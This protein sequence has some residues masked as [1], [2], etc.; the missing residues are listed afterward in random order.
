MVRFEQVTFTSAEATA[1]TGVSGTQQRNLRRHGYLDEP[2]HGTRWNRYEPADLAKLLLINELDRLHIPP[3][4]SSEI[5][6]FRKAAK[7]A[8]VLIL[9]FAQEC[10]GTLDDPFDRAGGEKPIKVSPGGVVGRYLVVSGEQTWLE[11]DRVA[12]VGSETDSPPVI[13]IDLQWIAGE[14][15]KRA[16]KPLWRVEG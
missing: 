2:H 12:V 10:D 11:K 3:S 13:V 4:F 7:S 9:A 15:V 14:L 8:A 6:S 16:K 1:I 5:A